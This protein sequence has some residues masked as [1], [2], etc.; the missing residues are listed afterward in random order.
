MRVACYRL[1]RRQLAAGNVF[2]SVWRA[3]ASA[4]AATSGLNCVLVFEDDVC[5][6]KNA[7]DVFNECFNRIEENWDLLYL[8]RGRDVYEKETLP[9]TG[10]HLVK[11]LLSCGTYA[12]AISR[13]GVAKLLKAQLEKA[14]IPVDEFLPACYVP[15]P[16]PDFRKLF[17]PVLNAWAIYP[18]ITF[19]AVSVSDSDTENSK[20]FTP[21]S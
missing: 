19:P 2:R 5:F 18:V 11:P 20:S 6:S 10:I 17:P 8:G 12:Y 13:Q 16:R 14:M 9:E 1:F 3:A 4:F 7:V 21:R 15:H